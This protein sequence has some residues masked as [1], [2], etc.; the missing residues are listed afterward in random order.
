M[1]DLDKINNNNMNSTDNIKHFVDMRLKVL[2]ISY[3][4]HPS[5]DS[6]TVSN[7]LG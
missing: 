6:Q 3:K 4:N 2:T 5:M 1:S 7:S